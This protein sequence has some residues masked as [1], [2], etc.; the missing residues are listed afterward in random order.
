LGPFALLKALADNPIECWTKAHFEEPIVM[1]GFPFARVAV[2]SDLIAIRHML[3]ENPSDYRKS[4]LERRILSAHLRDGLV[5][6]EGDQW[7]GQRRTLAPWFAR[8]MVMQLAPEMA[9]AAAALIGHW[10]DRGA[11]NVVDIKAEMSRL[12]LDRL[13]RCIFF[14]G[15]GEDP[16]AFRAAMMRSF[17]TAVRIDPF[18]LIGFP[19]FIPRLTRLRRRSSSGSCI[20]ATIG[21]RISTR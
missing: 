3:V 8:K 15:L 16:E 10:H 17:A 12:S 20:G 1:G 6:V 21:T 9:S 18:D 5:T 2:V 19:D 7:G 13:L 11:D 4:A 14:G